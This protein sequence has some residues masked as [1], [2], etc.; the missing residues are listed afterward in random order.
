MRVQRMQERA[1]RLVEEDEARS[2]AERARPPRPPQPQPP[3][4]PMA[5]AG[6]RRV[7][8]LR[9]RRN[10]AARSRLHRSLQRRRIPAGCCRCSAEIRNSCCC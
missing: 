6:R 4:P 10:A 9:V 2:R 3:E 7:W 1:R 8:R 5:A